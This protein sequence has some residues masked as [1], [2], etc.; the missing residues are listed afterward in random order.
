MTVIA[1]PQTLGQLIQARAECLP[2]KPI[3]TFVDFERSDEVITYGMLYTKAQKLGMFLRRHGITSG[4][5]FG[6]MMWNHPEFVY[7]LIAASMG[8]AILV[9]I[10]PRARGAKLQHQL[11]H[12][13]C[14]GL[15]VAD[16]AL[17]QVRAFLPQLPA[18][19][20]IRVLRTEAEGAS[21][22]M[23]DYP[24]LNDYLAGAEVHLP[25]MA[26]DAA[27]ALEIIYTS[28]TTGDPKGIVID[29]RRVL[30]FSELGRLIF[31]YRD[32]DR[33][34]TGL[35]LAHGNAQ[36]VTLMCALGQR[37]EAVLTRRFTKSRLWDLTRAYGITSFS[38]LGGMATAI[39]SEPRRS[40]DNDNPVRMIV[41]AG[42]P[43][44]IWEAFEQRYAV[45]LLEWYGAVEGGF[46]F[47]PIDAGP[48]GSF[49]RLSPGLELRV[50]D[51][52]ERA[53]PPGEVGELLF[54]PKGDV[55]RVNYWQ[56]PSA[57]RQKVRHGWLRSGDM[58]HQDEAGYLFFDCRKGEAIRRNGEFINPQDVTKVLAEHPDITDVFVYGVPARSGAPGE[59][60]LVAAIVLIDPAQCDLSGVWDTCRRALEANAVPSCL[61]V[62]LELPTTLSEKPQ[63]RL[64][65]EQFDPRGDN[66]LTPST[67]R[68]MAT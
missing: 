35:S 38:V 60:D 37:I 64:L 67:D 42:M 11:T 63:K 18:L 33:L 43:A 58:V 15:L 56:D 52:H 24:L 25:H 30:G 13:N 14:R 32:D 22:P 54:R 41:S 21:A 20:T 31:G 34:Y 53:C 27:Q 51:E 7:A 36:A 45:R 44:A 16:Y 50:V 47:K 9:P 5:T 62:V 1:T 3:L 17:D 26:S 2:D 59:Q 40:N 48:I 29:N 28:G 19:R 55:A 49:G 8:G 4:V 65:L 23:T 57:S 12:A 10:D 6:V 68:D 66:L 46:V 39:Y 61:Q